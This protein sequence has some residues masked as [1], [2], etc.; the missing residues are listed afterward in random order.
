MTFKR[1]VQTEVNCIAGLPPAL[2]EQTT[3]VDLK[4]G[5]DEGTNG[6]YMRL[7]FIVVLTI[8]YKQTTVCIGSLLWVEEDGE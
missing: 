3:S 6:R 1:T 5:S 2:T 7:S 4:E 8:D